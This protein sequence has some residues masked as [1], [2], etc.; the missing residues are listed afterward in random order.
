MHLFHRTSIV[1]TAI[2][3]AGALVTIALPAPTA[4]GLDD[5]AAPDLTAATD[6]SLAS[7]ADVD[8]PPAN[9]TSSDDI[10]SNK[11]PAFTVAD[12]ASIVSGDCVQLRRA[13]VVSGVP[14]TFT[15]VAA[16]LKGATTL[17]LT[18][19][20]DTADGTYAYQY[21]VFAATATCTTASPATA[22]VPTH[23]SLILSPVVVDTVA[24]VSELDLTTAS[25]SGRVNTDNVTS[26]GTNLKFLAAAE[27][28]SK[29]DLRRAGTKLTP[30][31]G[32]AAGEI[33]DA[34]TGLIAT[35]SYRYVA[36]YT[37]VAGNTATREL[38]VFID[39][40]NPGLPGKLDLVTAS[41]T[42]SSSGDDVTRDNTP[43]FTVSGAE[44]DAEVF[45]YRCP[46]TSCTTAN[47]VLLGTRIGNGEVTAPQL[48]DNVVASPSYRFAVGQR[49]LSGRFSGGEAG[50]TGQPAGMGVHINVVIDTVPE[51]VPT[52]PT[53]VEASRTGDP[54]ITDETSPTFNVA[55]GTGR[56][57]L[58]RDGVVVGVSTGAGDIRDP[59]PLADGALHLYTSRSVDNAG[60]ESAQSAPFAVTVALPK[61]VE[62]KNET[63]AKSAGK[64]YWLLGRD[65]GVFSFGDAGFFGSTGDMTL[66]APIVGMAT[67]PSKQGY[68]LLGRD[69]GVFSFGD[70]GFFGSTGD[71][72]LNSPIVGMVA[73]PS[74]QGYWL[75]AGDG[76]VFAFGDA[77][78]H[79]APAGDNPTSPIVAMLAT[80]DGKGYWLV[81]KNGK[82]Y[83][84]GSA[85][86]I[87]GVDDLTLNSPIVGFAASPTDQGLWLVAADGG[88]FALGDAVFH[89][90]AGDMRL[91]SPIIGMMASPVGDGYLLLAGDGGVFTYGAATFLGSTGDLVLNA[92]IVGIAAT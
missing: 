63:V 51:P 9:G 84:Y 23:S 50:V 78:F 34:G 1:A 77:P 58:L 48:V 15:T 44:E 76:G 73:T 13:P 53:L 19:A 62:V 32:V 22:S 85:R 21:R 82:V 80:K 69:G 89:G 66:N 16:A 42:G 59:G 39:L 87:A 3:T 83:A 56:V 92:P 17:T 55:T 18:T 5:L 2:V 61:P 74:G 29:V 67:T 52:T 57:Q 7:G 49:D 79:G 68:W 10:T 40:D 47:R 64:G 31:D 65:G 27:A 54:A 70:A 46:A 28:G 45:F 81:A 12:S 14:G 91:N 35:G 37:D 25:D 60:N 36:T 88:V 86:S 26:I 20:A 8:A 30:K 71:Q 24:T 11:R 6:S 38:F 90:S 33:T 4:W 41:D 43:T 72:V 75:F